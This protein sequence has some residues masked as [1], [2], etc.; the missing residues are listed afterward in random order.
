MFNPMF[1]GRNFICGYCTLLQNPQWTLIKALVN[2]V[3]STMHIESIFKPI[4][5]LFV[6]HLWSPLEANIAFLEWICMMQYLHMKT[7][8]NCLIMIESFIG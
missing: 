4:W 1:D 6:G 2:I 8:E 7:H 5:V 3:R